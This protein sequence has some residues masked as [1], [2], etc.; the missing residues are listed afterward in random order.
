MGAAAQAFA[1]RRACAGARRLR[2]CHAKRPSRGAREWRVLGR[3]RRGAPWARAAR[4]IQESLIR[5]DPLR[6]RPM[7][8]HM[9]GHRDAMYVLSIMRTMRE[10]TASVVL[11]WE[12]CTVWLG[13]YQEHILRFELQLLNTGP[14]R[15]RMVQ[16]VSGTYVYER[17]SASRYA[18]RRPHPLPP[19]LS[20]A[21]CKQ[22][23]THPF[24]HLQ[25]PLSVA[26]AGPCLQHLAPPAS[27]ARP[28]V[29]G[30]QA[31]PAAVPPP[32]HALYA[33]AAPA[34]RPRSPRHSPASGGLPVSAGVTGCDAATHTTTTKK[35]K[36]M[37]GVGS[38]QT[39]ALHVGVATHIQEG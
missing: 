3:Q 1:L 6:I 2:G 5:L 38:R 9:C 34:R 11:L 22:S 28:A 12:H 23:L 19:P 32:T 17:D 37:R 18:Y 36:A 26:A 15:L 16:T 7:H 33:P 14:P 13:V 24:L 27:C 39:G 31:Q 29:A 35:N 20:A 4:G 30:G 21:S 8:M 10:R 25:P